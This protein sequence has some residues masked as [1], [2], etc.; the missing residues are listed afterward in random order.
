LTYSGWAADYAEAAPVSRVIAEIDGV[1][2]QDAN[3]RYDRPDVVSGTGHS[4]WLNSGYRGAYNTR[5]LSIGQHTISTYAID[6]KGVTTKL[7]QQ[8]SFNVVAN[9][10]PMGDVNHAWDL[11]NGSTTVSRSSTFYA[12]GWAADAEDGAAVTKIEI[13]VDG[14]PVSGNLTTGQYRA[15]LESVR[16]DYANSGWEFTMPAST[17]S[18]GNHHVSVRVTDSMG[19]GQTITSVTAPDITVVQ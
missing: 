19:A 14:S 10:A 17:L 3:V 15:D 12:N 6:S 4:N 9:T 5:K 2:V 11:Q 16:S 7:A 18:L 8:I 1:Y 13:L